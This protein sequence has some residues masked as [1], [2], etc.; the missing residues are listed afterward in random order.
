MNKLDITLWEVT[1]RAEGLA[2]VL[3][4]GCLVALA[5]LVWWHR[6]PKRRRR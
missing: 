3:I 6:T 5:I 1:I 4:A 2:P